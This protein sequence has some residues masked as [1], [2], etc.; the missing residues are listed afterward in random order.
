MKLEEV[1]SVF[2]T[3][4]EQYE[5]RRV[6]EVVADDTTYRLEV[7]Y[8]YSNPNGRWNVRVYSQ[9]STDWKRE[10]DFPWVSE[11]N[12]ESAIHTALSFLKDRSSR[13]SK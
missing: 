5:L 3:F 4:S 11:R 10:T 1:F 2:K 6:L 12:E 8:S 13:R 7:L 9:V